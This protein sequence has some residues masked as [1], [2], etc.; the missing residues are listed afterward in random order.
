MMLPYS[1][2]LTAT[3][4]AS[5]PDRLIESF[6]ASR[7]ADRKILAAG[8]PEA[9]AASH[10][11]R[12]I[13]SFRDVAKAM[14]QQQAMKDRLATFFD[15]GWDAILMP[16]A[17]VTAFPH[18]HEGGFNDRVLDMDGGKIPYFSLLMWISLATF[19]H[20]PSVAVQAG[21][22]KAGMPVGVQLVGRWHGEDR[23]LD[24]AAGL[25]ENFGFSPPAL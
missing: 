5:L 17:P 16:I 7:E 13:V 8:G 12:T 2:I 9:A 3:L 15:E 19:L 20:A 21:R 25:E 6:E 18:L 10:R 1:T 14:M 11:L 4:S 22:N 24:L 23:L